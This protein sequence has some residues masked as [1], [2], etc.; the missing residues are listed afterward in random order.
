MKK[1]A[2]YFV[3]ACIISLYTHTA[4]A[5]IAISGGVAH[6]NSKKMPIDSNGIN[7]KYRYENDSYSVSWINSFLYTDTNELKDKFYMKSQYYGI[8]TGA[9]YRFNDWSSIYGG[10]GIGYSKFQSRHTVVIKNK[11]LFADF[12]PS[13]IL[14]IQFNPIKNFVIDLSYE[15]NMMRDSNTSTFTAGIGYNF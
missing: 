10:T 8:C 3:L 14:G 1:F 2:Y 15:T 4:S 11:F 5:H 12:G 9:A 13:F 6:G 7:L